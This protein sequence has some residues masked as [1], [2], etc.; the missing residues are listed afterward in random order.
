MCFVFITCQ[1]SIKNEGDRNVVLVT[2][3]QNILKPEKYPFSTYLE[4]FYAK[5]AD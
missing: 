1:M 5:G 2:H 4:Q 3:K